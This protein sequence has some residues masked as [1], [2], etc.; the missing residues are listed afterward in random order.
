MSPVEAS[1][2]FAP[3]HTLERHNDPA[4]NR[5]GRSLYEQKA[6]RFRPGVTEISL[7]VDHDRERQV[8]TVDLVHRMEWT[9]GP[10]MVARAT[11]TDPPGWLRTNDTKASF[12]FNAL[13]R[14]TFTTCEHVME[15]LINEVSILSP[16][17][18]PAEPLA[19]VLSLRAVKPAVARAGT[20]G[21]VIYGNGQVIRRYFKPPAIVVR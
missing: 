14:G 18:Q 19:R 9:D 15:A 4:W 21:E 11:V 5:E 2:M 7:L 16:G 12:A 3:L 1:I 20:E 6:F 17:K 8:G 13:A 10:W